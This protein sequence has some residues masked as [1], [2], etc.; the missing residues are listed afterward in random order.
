MAAIISCRCLN[1]KIR[2]S[3]SSGF[4]AQDNDHGPSPAE[5]VSNPKDCPATVGI[6]GISIEHP[7]LIATIIEHGRTWIKCINCDTI[8]YG[9]QRSNDQSTTPPASEGFLPPTAEIRLKIAIDDENSKLPLGHEVE[10]LK[11]APNYSSAFNIRLVAASSWSSTGNVEVAGLPISFQTAFENLQRSLLTYNHQKRLEVEARIANYTATQMATFEMEQEKARA[12][13]GVIWS[14][15]CEANRGVLSKSTNSGT[16]SPSASLD[17]SSTAASPGLTTKD[18][19]GSNRLSV[20]SN[21]ARLS[22]SSFTPSVSSSSTTSSEFSSVHG[23]LPPAFRQWSMYMK[24]SSCSPPGSDSLSSGDPS[25][26]TSPVTSSIPSPPRRIKGAWSSSSLD[27]GSLSSKNPSV[28]LADQPVELYSRKLGQELLRIMLE[29]LSNAVTDPSIHDAMIFIFHKLI[30]LNLIRDVMDSLRTSKMPALT[31]F[32]RLHITFLKLVDEYVKTR[33]R[34]DPTK[35]PI[36]FDTIIFLTKVIEKLVSQAPTLLSPV[37]QNEKENTR[38]QQSDPPSG[39]SPLQRSECLATGLEGLSLLLRIMSRLTVAMKPEQKCRL[40]LEGL[41]ESVLNLLKI[42]DELLPRR[43]LPLSPGIGSS[44]STAYRQGTYRF[45]V[46]LISVLG[47][48]CAGSREAQDEIRRLG[49]VPLILSQAH[50]DDCNPFLREYTILAIRNLLEKNVENQRIVASLEARQVVDQDA[51]SGT[52]L[53]AERNFNGSDCRHKIYDCSVADPATLNSLIIYQKSFQRYHTYMARKRKSGAIKNTKPSQPRRRKSAKIPFKVLESNKKAKQPA[54]DDDDP[55]DD[56]D[57]LDDDMY[58]RTQLDLGFASDGEPLSDCDAWDEEDEVVDPDEEILMAGPNVMPSDAVPESHS[59]ESANHDV[60]VTAYHHPTISQNVWPTERKSSI[61]HSQFSSSTNGTM[62]HKASFPNPILNL[63]PLDSNEVH[64]VPRGNVIPSH[65]AAQPWQVPFKAMSDT[66]YLS[67]DTSF[68]RSK[69]ANDVSEETPVKKRLSSNNNSYATATGSSSS[70]C[71]GKVDSAIAVRTNLTMFDYWQGTST[72]ETPVGSDKPAGFSAHPLMTGSSVK[73]NSKS[74]TLLRSTTEAPGSETPVHQH[75]K[76]DAQLETPAPAPGARQ[77]SPGEVMNVLRQVLFQGASHVKLHDAQ[78]PSAIVIPQAT[79]SWPSWHNKAES[80]NSQSSGVSSHHLKLLRSGAI[81]SGDETRTWSTN[82]VGKASL[83]RPLEEDNDVS[84]P[85]SPTSPPP[86]FGNTTKKSRAYGITIE[87]PARSPNKR[88]KLM[89]PKARRDAED[90]VGEKDEMDAFFQDDMLLQ[91]GRRGVG[92]E[93]MIVTGRA[94]PFSSTNLFEGIT[95]TPRLPAVSEKK[96]TQRR[97]SMRLLSSSMSTFFPKLSSSS[98]LKCRGSRTPKM[99]REQRLLMRGTPADHLKAIDTEW[100]PVEKRAG[101]DDTFASPLPHKQKVPPD[102]EA[103][104]ETLAEGTSKLAELEPGASNIESF[105]SDMVHADPHVK[106]GVVMESSGSMDENAGSDSTTT[107]QDEH[108]KDRSSSRSA[109]L[110][111]DKS[112]QNHENNFV[113]TINTESGHEVV[114]C[115]DQRGIDRHEDDRVQSKDRPISNHCDNG[116]EVHGSGSTSGT[117]FGGPNQEVVPHEFE[118]V[119]RHETVFVPMRIEP[120]CNDKR[121]DVEEPIENTTTVVGTNNDDH[122]LAIDGTVPG[123]PVKAE[124]DAVKVDDKF[125]APACTK[126]SNPELGRS[127]IIEVNPAN[128]IGSVGPRDKIAEAEIDLFPDVVTTERHFVAVNDN[129]LPTVEDRNIESKSELVGQ[130]KPSDS[131]ASISYDDRNLTQESQEEA[132]VH[133]LTQMYKKPLQAPEP[134]VEFR[135]A[136]QKPIVI[137][138]QSFNLGIQFSQGRELGPD[139]GIQNAG[140]SNFVNLTQI[141]RAPLDP[142]TYLPQP[143]QSSCKNVVFP[144]HAGLSQRFRSENVFTRSQ[145]SSDRPSQMLNMSQHP[146]RTQRPVVV[147]NSQTTVATQRRPAWM[148]LIPEED[149]EEGSEIK[150]Y[151]ENQDEVNTVNDTT[152]NDAN[153]MK[154]DVDSDN[155]A[156][157]GTGKLRT[158]QTVNVVTALNDDIENM[159]VYDGQRRGHCQLEVNRARPHGQAIEY[160]LNEIKV[161]IRRDNDRFL[162]PETPEGLFAGFR[163]AKMKPLPPISEAARKRAAAFVMESLES[164]DMTSTRQNIPFTGDK[165]TVED[166]E[167]ATDSDIRQDMDMPD[168]EVDIPLPVVQFGDYAAPETAQFKF[169]GFSSAFKLASDETQAANYNRQLEVKNQCLGLT[170]GR[171]VSMAPP[172]ECQHNDGFLIVQDLRD[173]DIYST[174]DDRTPSRRKIPKKTAFKVPQMKGSLS[175]P[176]LTIRSLKDD[177]SCGNDDGSKSLA[178][179]P[180]PFVRRKMLPFKSPLASNS[181]GSATSKFSSKRRTRLHI[182]FK[183]AGLCELPVK[184]E[185]KISKI[186]NLEVESPRQGLRAAIGRPL[187]VAHDD[188]LIQH[189][190]DDVIYCNA[191][192]AATHRFEDY[193]ILKAR[194]DLV[195]FGA[196]PKF[197]TDPWVANHWKWIVEKLAAMIRSKPSLYEECWKPTAVLNQL[198]YRYEREINQAHRSALKLIIERDES[199]SKLMVLYVAVIHPSNGVTPVP[200][201]ELT[202]GWYCIRACMDRSLLRQL[203]EGK[204]RVGLKLRIYSAKLLGPP[205]PCPALEV[206]STTMLQLCINSTRLARWDAKLGFQERRVEAVALRSIVAEGGDVPCIDVVIMRRFPARYM[207]NSNGKRVSRSEREEDAAATEYENAIQQVYQSLAMESELDSS[208]FIDDPTPPKMFHVPDDL[209][210]IESAEEL[211]KYMNVYSDT[212]DF[213]GKLTAVQRDQ[214]QDFIS[215]R[216]EQYALD[217]RTRMEDE[218][219]SRIKP[220]E[221]SKFIKFR[222]CDYPPLGAVCEHVKEAFLTVWNVD[223]SVLSC[224]AEGKRL[225]IFGVMAGKERINN[226]ERYPKGTM[227]PMPL[228]TTRQLLFQEMPFSTRDYSRTLYQ[229]RKWM[230]CQELENLERFDVTD[231]VAVLIAVEQAR[232]VPGNMNRVTQRLACTD[233]SGH[234]VIIRLSGQHMSSYPRSSFSPKK[235]IA[236]LNL[237]YEQFCE[238][239]FYLRSSH[240]TDV[241]LSALQGVGKGLLDELAAWIN[242]V[243][244][245][246]DLLE[247]GQS[248]LT[249]TSTWHG[250]PQTMVQTGTTFDTNAFNCNSQTLDSPLMRLPPQQLTRPTRPPGLRKSTSPSASPRRH[251]QRC[252]SPSLHLSLSPHRRLHSPPN[253]KSKSPLN[254][255]GMGTEGKEEMLIEDSMS[256]IIAE[257]G[258]VR[259]V[260]AYV[261]PFTSVRTSTVGDADILVSLC[262]GSTELMQDLI[263]PSESTSGD[264]SN[265]IVVSLTLDA[266]RLIPVRMTED[267]FDNMLKSAIQARKLSEP[268]E[269]SLTQSDLSLRWM[270]DSAAD[271]RVQRVDQ[272]HDIL[273]FQ[274]FQFVLAPEDDGYIAVSNWRNREQSMQPSSLDR[275][276]SNDQSL[277]K[278]PNVISISVRPPVEV[279]GN[280]LRQNVVL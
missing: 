264:N 35:V 85:Q 59:L 125:D 13:R 19:V 237:E 123:N 64:L 93:G 9:F 43:K 206:T 53:Q 277:I 54:L 220:R 227:M 269:K 29:R 155:Y 157:D 174:A 181:L 8:V 258:K 270:L 208:R 242:N 178:A 23:S 148:D 229:P 15:I 259:Q 204:I 260:F 240:E 88:P 139:S 6:G 156:P 40:V 276:N 248:A 224:F 151:T 21:N 149:E 268:A 230:S 176:H 188:L 185:S 275:N 16:R 262:D 2:L 63:S 84:N 249:N 17:T 144:I 180:V 273:C 82:E 215:R 1:I 226:H 171:N 253:R 170:T 232:I 261:L 235:P 122:T 7:I 69:D 137:S 158:D 175:A 207:E 263:F 41:L 241:K 105:S 26:L 165:S 121:N 104:V 58:R 199:P 75:L 164:D 74:P 42:A 92:R 279:L 221:V 49:G 251:A 108:V 32:D 14:R 90:L 141:A 78:S 22:P 228:R 183:A 238:G 133:N 160:G 77:Q 222:V 246:Q 173:G 112:R 265:G 111:V 87:S 95:C 162:L 140:K 231:L 255:H 182:D 52:G 177:N 67:H 193:A 27:G 118:G 68:P 194:D 18:D 203:R 218:M 163:T 38:Q 89:S 250:V 129:D 76:W 234:I 5:A 252:S 267:M 81:R 159:T 201:L 119:E 107:H 146:N 91:V 73:R 36:A 128:R 205:E 200:T 106:D 219:Q 39:L 33:I 245:A 216:Q 97:Q 254:R 66:S 214:L 191:T 72:T 28:T 138:R 223:D 109:E 116:Q 45:K 60:N 4:P 130:M 131:S 65:I 135:T 210:K 197:A 124:S 195:A 236:F 145:V 103:V 192:S 101:S 10:K 257:H 110:C 168:V 11:E 115:H 196:D 117:N 187:Q 62:K 25:A 96:L 266:G 134:L 179:T 161:D 113:M 51:L 202:D 100:T 31:I 152:S 169:V 102:D 86:I 143:S 280:L 120:T 114:D 48:L 154:V 190:P 127:N 243:E 189:I 217:M 126:D 147:S 71:G 186:F 142:E 44:T 239:A 20:S 94:T 24:G 225:R 50:I 256:L 61:L 47:N 166:T 57:H 79:H 132:M 209:S 70:I 46:N 56:A 247:Q 83:K 34:E 272:V 278:G 172:D 233:S 150:N 3:S 80:M 212:I 136:S 184:N 30:E 198:R 167:G 213:M 153:L 99:S 271:D 55:I 211:Y 274:D 37:L 244:G 12:E 98:D